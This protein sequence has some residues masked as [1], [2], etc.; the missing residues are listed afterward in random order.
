MKHIPLFESFDNSNGENRCIL[1]AANASNDDFKT[2][3]KKVEDELSKLF[4][5]LVPNE[6]TAETIEGEM[7]RAIMRVWYRYY[8]DG[9]Y[10]FRGYGKETVK[11]SVDWLCQVSPL[12]DIMKECFAAA[13][14]EALPAGHRD[15][16]TS[17]DGYLRNIIEIAQVIVDHIN[18]LN[19]KYTPL[20][21]TPD[22]RDYQSKFARKRSKY[23]AW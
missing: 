6:G 21:E 4:K 8:N 19:G 10:Y 7:V 1:E 14:A 13:K 9:D 17:N 20:G 18:G 11:P 16:F 5:K 12:K 22:S 15:E 23:A 3:E 2:K